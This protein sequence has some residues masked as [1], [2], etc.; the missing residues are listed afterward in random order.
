MDE[1]KTCKTDVKVYEYANPKSKVFYT[2][3]AGTQVH[4]DGVTDN[5]YYRIAVKYPDGGEGS[6]YIEENRMM[7]ETTQTMVTFVEKG[8]LALRSAPEF[9]DSN[10]IGKLFNDC[11]VE[12][13]GQ[14]DGNYVMVRVVE[15]SKKTNQDLVG[16]TGYVDVRHLI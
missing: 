7:G 5:G 10:I 9:K 15:A 8:F 12:V 1:T 13:I 16:K 11:R 6:G 3:K 4:V 14:P 2:L